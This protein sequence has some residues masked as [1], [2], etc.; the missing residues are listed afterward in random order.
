M[1]IKA[2]AIILA[3][4][5]VIPSII[6]ASDPGNPDHVI[7]D[8]VET[9]AG[10]SIV[11]SLWIV[12]DDTTFF[13]DS[14]WTGIG[15]FCI[16]LRY[17]VKALSADSVVFLNTLAEWDEHFTN[18]RIDTGFVSISGIFNL[19]GN[20]NLPIFAAEK[21]EEVAM[22]FFKVREDARPGVYDIGLTIDPIQKEMYF[23]SPDG[24]HGWR[25]EFTTG[26]VVV[27]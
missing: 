22:I 16:P 17:D 25:P 13:D 3:I 5:Y 9:K 20:D 18:R 11:I 24:M 6:F 19:G 7:L 1:I 4:F 8:S 12:V 26:K 2:A 27:K 23:G 15:S 14:S 10:E 21:P